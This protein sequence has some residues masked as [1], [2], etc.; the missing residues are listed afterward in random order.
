VIAGTLTN[1]CCESSARDATVLNFRTIVISDANA[2]R[3]NTE[4]NA[5]LASIYTAFGDVMDTK[6]LIK[7]LTI[8]TANKPTA[9]R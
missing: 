6:Y 4:H 1:I 9:G 7:R 5:A 8:N 3:S 2:A